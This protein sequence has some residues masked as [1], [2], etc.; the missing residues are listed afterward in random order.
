MAKKI[1]LS[2]SN[3]TKNYYASGNTT[4]AI[5][6]GRIASATA[7]ALERCGFEVKT[8][9][10][11][12]MATK[13]AESNKWG[14]D[15]HVPIHTNAH[16]GKV[17]GT[18]LF[19]FN[20][21]GAGYKAA[22]AV[23]NALAPV[24]PGKSE[25]VSAYPGLYEIKYAKAP[26]VYIEAEFHDVPSV[27]AWIIA[28]VV[29]IG[30]AICKGICNYFGVTY[31]APKQAEAEPTPEKTVAEKAEEDGAEEK[32]AKVLYRVVV[33][34]SAETQIGAFSVKGNAENLVNSLK[35]LGVTWVEIKQTEAN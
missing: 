23:F 28:H 13:V 26:T 33:K 27:A 30:E 5:Q 11:G 16:N 32:K 6:C 35:S 25:N 4:E 18:R 7:T 14:A 8:N 21:S 10:Y 22:K 24:T 2:P 34:K 3:Q 29:D 31:V 1:F 15:L 19:S 20:T 17:S 9:H 12:T